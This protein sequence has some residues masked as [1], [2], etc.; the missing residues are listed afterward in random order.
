MKKSLTNLLV[1][2]DDSFY[3]E[4]L[5]ESLQEMGYVTETANNGQHAW[6]ILT[7]SAG[8][9]DAVLLDRMM[10]VMDGMEL[11]TRIR[12]DAEL[13]AL[14]V[15]MQTTMSEKEEILQGL[16]AG[17]HYYLIKPFEKDQLLAIVKTAVQDYQRIQSM[18]QETTKTIQ[19]L[20]L[21]NQG[22]FTFRSLQEGRDLVMLISRAFPAASKIVMGL[23]ELVI[24]AVEHGNLS[25]GY[26]DKSRLNKQGIWEQE[27]AR[28]LGLPENADK[29][30]KLTFER[31]EQEVKFQIEDQG[32]GFNWEKYLEISPERAF[33][34]HGRGIAMAKLISFDHLEYRGNGSQVVATVLLN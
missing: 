10:P 22:S 11:L 25:I 32:Q 26:D 27:V 31:N 34:T 16:K 23:S 30:V 6:D 7:E 3:L 8:R 1:V 28:R 33:D 29:V 21:M 9:F 20:A 5:C 18:Q 12:A 4:V 13:Q 2:D 19:T 17:A 14:P 24:N 15:I